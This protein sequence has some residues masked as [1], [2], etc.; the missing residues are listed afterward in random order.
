MS[1]IMIAVDLSAFSEEVINKG[2]TLAQKMQTSVTLLSVVEV[3]LGI[4]LPET[5]AELPARIR[6]TEEQLA[7]FKNQYPGADIK[8][9]VATGNPKMVTLEVAH[10]NN[11]SMLVVGTHGRTGLDH[12][13]IGSTAEY[14][15]RHARIP[16]L[17]VPY[18]KEDH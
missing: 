8:I 5:V 1:D 2:V 4:A 17:V 7:E 10:E 3:G 9:V 15:I 18:N 6:D 13:L 16:V 12:M 14:I 11:A